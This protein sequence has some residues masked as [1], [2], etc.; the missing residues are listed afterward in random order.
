MPDDSDFEV[1]KVQ[2]LVVTSFL[3]H[4]YQVP[5]SPRHQFQKL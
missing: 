3:T 5:M 4:I 1:E 2:C